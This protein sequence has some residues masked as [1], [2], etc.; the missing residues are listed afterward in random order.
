MIINYSQKKKELDWLENVT[1]VA[2]LVYTAT[3]ALSV[4]WI[5]TWLDE[6]WNEFNEELEEKFSYFSWF[7]RH[8]VVRRPESEPANSARRAMGPG[9]YETSLPWRKKP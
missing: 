1:H 2:F 4:W 5:R 8:T 6:K 7:S 9:G 3:M